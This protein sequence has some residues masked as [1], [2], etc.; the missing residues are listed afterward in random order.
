MPN[1]KLSRKQ[2]QYERFGETIRYLTIEEWQQFLDVIEH[3]RHKLIMRMVYELGCRVGE[4]VR[5]QLKHMAFGRNTV[6]FPAENTKTKQ[7][8]VSHLPPGLMNELKSLLRR[9]GPFEVRKAQPL[10][11]TIDSLWKSVIAKLLDRGFSAYG[12]RDLCTTCTEEF[13]DWLM[14]K[15]E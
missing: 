9:E 14:E 5:I 3:Y 8:R 2:Q 1:V 13:W 12:D 4:F 10:K 15:E 7:R 11:I 6:Y